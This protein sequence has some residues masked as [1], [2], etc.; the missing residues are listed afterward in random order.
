[1]KDAIEKPNYDKTRKITTQSDHKIVIT[2]LLDEHP[3]AY[4]T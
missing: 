1:M 4:S 3:A 2:R